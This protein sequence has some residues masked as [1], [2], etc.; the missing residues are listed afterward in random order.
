MS[1]ANSQAKQKVIKSAVSMEKLTKK[2]SSAPF[3][4]L[5]RRFSFSS[6]HRLHNPRWDDERNRTV[7]G[8]CNNPNG[9]ADW[10]PLCGVC[11][12]VADFIPGHG[13]NYVVYVTL[14]GQVD[15]D[16]GMVVNL[17]DVKQVLSVVEARFD[18]RHLDKDVPWF[19]DF[20][21]VST[22]ENVCIALWE[23]IVDV[24]PQMGALLSRIEVRETENNIFVYHGPSSSSQ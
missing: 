8:K 6:A 12:L 5:C 19:R 10:H 3:V 1:I 11:L 4:E 2:L 15:P 13:H 17:S 14:R 24:D 22:T 23:A 7:Y 16:S 20:G 9:E 21:R 18:H